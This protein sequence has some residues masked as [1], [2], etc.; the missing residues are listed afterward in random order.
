MMGYSKLEDRIKNGRRANT[1][2][3]EIEIHYFFPR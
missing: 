3:L 1:V 2:N